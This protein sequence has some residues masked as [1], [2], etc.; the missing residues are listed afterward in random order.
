MEVLFFS[1][2]TIDILSKWGT[3]VITIILNK[4]HIQPK[5]TSL[6]VFCSQ[7]SLINYVVFFY[8]IQCKQYTSDECFMHWLQLQNCIRFRIKTPQFHRIWPSLL[9]PVTN[10]TLYFH[11]SSNCT[12]NVGKMQWLNEINE[13]YNISNSKQ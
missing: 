13:C 6:I 7:G 3:V 12:F 8:N 2:C 11:L 4:A 9:V 10:I 5:I 1:E